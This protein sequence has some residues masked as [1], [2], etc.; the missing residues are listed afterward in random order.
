MSELGIS[1]ENSR[2]EFYSLVY[3]KLAFYVG[4]DENSKYDVFYSHYPV[5]ISFIII[6]VKFR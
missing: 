1:F 4:H 5:H 6:I 2:Y 3:L